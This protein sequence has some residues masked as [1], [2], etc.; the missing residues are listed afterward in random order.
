MPETLR[1]PTVTGLDFLQH[2]PD[3][4][5]HFHVLKEDAEKNSC[6][7]RYVGVIDVQ[8]GKIAASLQQ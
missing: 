1:D 3:F 7:L 2:L 4:D 8:Q 6:V 5:E